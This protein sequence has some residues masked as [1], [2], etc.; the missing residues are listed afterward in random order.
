M[1]RLNH[2]L[3]AVTLLL[4]ALPATASGAGPRSVGLPERQV[5]ALIA[6]HH[7]AGLDRFVRAVTDP[8]SPR[9]RHYATVEQL[10]ARFGAKPKAKRRVLSWL[11][12]RGVH[13]TVL[14]GGAYVLATMPRALAGELVPSREAGGA[15]HG[16]PGRRAPAAVRGAIAGVSLLD[17]RPVALDNALSSRDLPSQGAGASGRRKPYESVRHHSGTA[18]GCAAGS[19]GG[20]GPGYEPFT[21][22]QYLTAYGDAA[23]HAKGLE[24]QGQ[25]VA[26]VETGGFKRSDIATFGRCFGV[27]PPPT[28]VVRVGR[29]AQPPEDETTLDVSML[30]VGAPK[31]DRIFVYEGGSEFGQIVRTTAAALGSRGHHPN[32]ISI[33]QGSC[34][35]ALTGQLQYRDAFDRIFATAAGA[36]ISVLVSAGD[37]GSSACFYQSREEGKTALGVRG[38]SMPASS[39][40]ATAVGGTNLVLSK[41]NRIEHEFVWNDSFWRTPARVYHFPFAGGGGGSIFSPHTPWWQREFE[42]PYGPGRKLPDLSALADNVP[43][44][45]LF[46]TARACEPENDAVHGWTSVGGTSAATPLTAAGIALVNQYAAEH[47]Q[48]PVGFLNPLLYALGANAR[49]RKGAFHDV[50]KGNNDIGRALATAEEP[51]GCCSAKPGYDWASGWGS[52]KVSGFA[53]L[54]VA[55]GR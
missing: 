29:V 4:A 1:R 49:T 40:Y 43:G 15:A 54:A 30:A 5:D 39:Q 33:S 23:M 25:T 14:G 36:G 11:S 46:C 9:Y 38:V 42:R 52:L 31:L 47:R 48:R 7:P 20:H 13:G 10:V 37:Q 41:R 28:T 45:A 27:K 51:L 12:A 19:S 24:G 8:A 16:R 32:V 18:S 53:K 35:S 2:S 6:L 26:V 34:E 50:V 22:N 21:P 44:Y 3:L 55:A 17:R